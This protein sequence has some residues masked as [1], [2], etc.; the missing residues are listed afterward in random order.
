M[1]KFTIF[2]KICLL[3]CAA[4]ASL[5]LLCCFA[6][7]SPTADPVSSY[8]LAYNGEQ[9]S[10]PP[11]ER[12]FKS[13]G[14]GVYTLETELDVGEQ[15][16]INKVGSTDKIGFNELFSAANKLIEG[17][18]QSLK[19]AYEGKYVIHFD[20]SINFITYTYTSTAT[21]TGV[22][23]TNY[24][25]PMYTGE[26]HRFTAVANY[27][28]GTS[29]NYATIEWSSDNTDVAIVNAKGIV[30]AF[31][32]GNAKITATLDGKSDTVDIRIRPTDV[33][34]TGVEIN[35]ENVEMDVGETYELSA[36]I[37]PKN[38]DTAELNVSWDSS[39]QNVATVSDG[40]VTAIGS[41]TTTITVSTDKGGYTAECTVTVVE[42]VTAIKFNRSTLDLVVNG[43]E[44]TLSVAF[45]PSNATHKEVTFSI[46]NGRRAEIT[47]NGDGTLSVKGLTEGTTTI[48]AKSKDGNYTATCNVTVHAQNTVM[49]DMRQKDVRIML[50]D[51]A[52]LSLELDNL[53]ESDIQYV[54]WQSSNSDV[55]SVQQG[56]MTCTATAHQFGSAVVTAEVVDTSNNRYKTECNILV[57]DDFFFIYGYGLGQ[58]DFDWS[59][60]SDRDGAKKANVL[61]EESAVSGIYTLTRYLTPANG[62]QIIFNHVDSF[63]TAADGSQ[64]AVWNKDIKDTN[65][66]FDA[67]NSDTAYIQNTY[68]QFRVK[69]A[70]VYTIT[71]DL[72]GDMAKVVI[73][74]QSI[75][76]TDIALAPKKSVILKTK[77]SSVFDITFNPSVATIDPNDIKVWFESDFE[78]YEDYIRYELD[79]DNL[80]LTVTCEKQPDI[81]F[82]AWLCVSVNDVVGKIELIVYSSESQETLVENIEFENENYYFNVNNGGKAW[83][84]TVKAF[85][86]DDATIQAV[87]YSIPE[88]SGFSI[89][90]DTGV[91][92]ATHLG[93]IIVTAT[94]VGDESKT[95]TCSVTF[96]S[97]TFYLTGEF[98][99]SYG[100]FDN[101]EALSP[102]AKTVSGTKFQNFKFTQISETQYELRINLKAIKQVGTSREQY[103]FQ[104]AHLGMD[105]QWTSALK[106]STRNAL[107]CYQFTTYFTTHG[108]NTGVKVD[109]DYIIQIDLSNPSPKWTINYAGV[110]L[111]K[112]TLNA[113][114]SQISLNENLP[115]E[116]SFAPDFVTVDEDSISYTVDGKN[117]SDYVDVVF[118]YS[119]LTFNLS[120]KKVEFTEDKIITFT[121]TVSDKTASIDITL[122][123]QHHLEWQHDGS[124]HWQKCV[125]CD[126][127]TSP[128][129]HSKAEEYTITDPEGHYHLCS[130][131][132]AKLDFATHSFTLTDGWYNGETCSTCG[133]SAFEIDGTVLNKY[134][135]NFAK[136]KIPDNITQ[137]S[138]NAFENNT[139]LTAVKL[140]SSL[141]HIMQ[142]AF[143]GCVNLVEDIDMPDSLTYIYRYAFHGVRSKIVWGSSS[144]MY[145][146]EDECF[147]GYLGDSFSFPVV[148]HSYIIGDAA[149]ANC[150]NL[151]TF[152]LE[153]KVVG[154]F[155]IGMFS[156]CTNLEYVSFI[157]TSPHGSIEGMFSGCTSLKKVLFVDNLWNI[158]MNSF[159]GCE[160]LEAV[161]IGRDWTEDYNFKIVSTVG[162]DALKGKLYVYAASN[163]GTNLDFGQSSEYIAGTWHYTDDEHKSLDTVELWN[164][165]PQATAI[166][167]FEDDRRKN[168][169]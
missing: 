55:V 19:V 21:V 40:V 95:A 147:E 137:I 67:Q 31:S 141:T 56:K 133:F 113:Q 52:I 8:Y 12:M 69:Y 131:C 96:Y 84:Q 28:D 65:T 98:T 94:A 25:T 7:C 111:Q 43:V 78:G 148:S 54:V 22:E 139:F 33:T 88:T 64:T 89:N 74:M 48:S 76:I 91:V 121:C 151:K 127:A 115:I 128:T 3:L 35:E 18:N 167:L 152:V 83:A 157:G 60:V 92:T 58:K 77:E 168:L 166:T 70:G 140:P 159:K 123:A 15:F 2:K 75:D 107:G 16:T 104:I 10:A 44:K 109:G 61:L 5:A 93:T 135:G 97:D 46:T 24:T 149:L 39:N 160:A 116:L 81:E 59:Y 30:T 114:K 117:D 82:N 51:S 130:D 146:F 45:V 101:F 103:G 36:T 72:T 42:H 162:N 161:Y 85:V 57:A 73:K 163:P 145:K 102:S 29:D 119:T 124:T 90:P 169:F 38:E 144:A 71:L 112:I 6:A 105:V 118:D 120:A 23:I 50:D 132:G 4:A 110:G 1:G 100:D 129:S 49:A 138:A 27:S 99:S 53:I 87:K 20:E 126:Y 17:D 86:N 156:G 68:D 108:D 63:T 134:S 66:Y 150:I 41:G 79:P 125:D 154:A 155:G 34:V 165:K 164:A 32:Q 13:E 122:L 106:G 136:V 11:Q 47:D 80:L 153:Q 9:E 14:N 26:S 37:L 158:G 143:S 142:Y 62:F